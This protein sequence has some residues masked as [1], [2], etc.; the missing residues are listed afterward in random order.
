[1]LCQ[2]IMYFCKFPG[3]HQFSLLIV[4]LKRFGNPRLRLLSVT[5]IE[6]LI[7]KYDLL[8][9]QFSLWYKKCQIQMHTGT[10]N[11]L[12][13]IVYLFVINVQV[14]T[15]YIGTIMSWANAKYS[16]RSQRVQATK[17]KKHKA[18]LK[19]HF[20]SKYCGYTILLKILWVC[21]IIDKDCLKHPFTWM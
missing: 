3:R 10:N 6:C 9:L 5:I 14:G 19:I 1:M 11:L 8:W 18:Y 15:L 13:S 20:I 17:L 7:S 12:Y 21:L 2:F 4:K 16:V